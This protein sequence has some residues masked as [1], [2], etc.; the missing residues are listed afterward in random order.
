MIRRCAVLLVVI[1]ATL[2]ACGE[3]DQALDKGRRHPDTPAWQSSNTAYDAP[4][5]TPGDK[6][7]WESQLARRAQAQNDYAPK[8]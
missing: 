8:Q 1:G 6:A 7:R 2:T 4:G 3:R 5:Y